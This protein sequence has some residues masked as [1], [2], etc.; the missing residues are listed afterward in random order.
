MERHQTV[1]RKIALVIDDSTSD[2]FNQRGITTTTSETKSEAISEDDSPIELKIGEA[3]INLKKRVYCEVIKETINDG[4]CLGERETKIKRKK[5]QQV[6]QKFPVKLMK[7]LERKGVED[8][9]K[10]TNDGRSFVIKDKKAL[11]ATLFPLY[12]KEVK[13]DS[14]IRKL[15]RWGFTKVLRGE[16]AGAFIQKNFQ[17]G[18]SRLCAKVKTTRRLKEDDTKTYSSCIHTQPKLPYPRVSSLADDTLMNVPMIHRSDTLNP[19]SLINL[20]NNLTQPNLPTETLYPRVSTSE[21][22]LTNLEMEHILE[23]LRPRRPSSTIDNLSILNL[24]S[25]ITDATYSDLVM[26]HLTEHFN[27]RRLNGTINHRNQPSLPI[28]ILYPIST[29]VNSPLM[30]MPMRH[31]SEPLN[32]IRHISNTNQQEEMVNQFSS[33]TLSKL[34]EIQEE[35]ENKHYN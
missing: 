17:R 15:Y 4:G 12:F 20:V 13:Y 26:T 7:M 8:I 24:P 32:T 29:M 6:P 33:E 21:A 11:V 22:R 16:N 18:E 23:P 19:R 9:I 30:N 35:F 28:E 31:H 27:A 10:W 25:M 1:A 14:F 3:L 5:T 2:N 34:V